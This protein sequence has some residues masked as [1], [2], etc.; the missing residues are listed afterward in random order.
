MYSITN[1]P[2]VMGWKS[3]PPA[4]VRRFYSKHLEPYSIRDDITIVLDKN[5]NCTRSCVRHLLGDVRR[6]PQGLV[7]PVQ[8]GMEIRW[9]YLTSHTELQSELALYLGMASLRYNETSQLFRDKLRI[10]DR[11]LM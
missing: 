7:L 3:Q 5:I 10:P 1:T 8:Q 2:R 11:L 4:M 9:L 6:R